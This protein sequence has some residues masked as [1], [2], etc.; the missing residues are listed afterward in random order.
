MRGSNIESK[1]QLKRN[2]KISENTMHIHAVLE[3]VIA[4]ASIPK[5]YYEL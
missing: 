2:V 3:V 4:S 5:K 1:T